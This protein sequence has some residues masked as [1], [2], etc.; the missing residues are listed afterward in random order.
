M[1][2][3]Y[4]LCGLVFYVLCLFLEF[5]TFFGKLF[6]KHMNLPLR[7]AVIAD[8]MASLLLPCSSYLGCCLCSCEVVPTYKVMFT[9]DFYFRLK[10][11]VP[12]STAFKHDCIPVPLLVSLLW[13]VN[14]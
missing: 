2:V 4:V 11:G 8:E 12:L 14:E 3:F 5:S 6:C 10:F 13:V 7:Y 9:F 1:F